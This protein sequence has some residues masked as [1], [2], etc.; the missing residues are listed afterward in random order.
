MKAWNQSALL[1]AI[2]CASAPAMAQST[3]FVEPTRGFVLER[4]MTAPAK[5]VSAD[6][7]AGL[8]EGQFGGGIRVGLPNSELILRGGK[9]NTA[10]PQAN[11]SNEALFKYS[12]PGLEDTDRTEFDWSLYGGFG[13]T[14]VDFGDYD[15]HRTN[16]RVGTA[17]TMTIDTLILNFA[18]EVVYGRYSVDGERNG[19]D[20]DSEDDDT[21][22]NFGVGAYFNLPETDYGRF[23]PGIEAGFST[24]DDQDAIVN[25]GVR[26]MVKDRV[27]LDVVMINIGDADTFSFPGV[28][29]LNV[30]F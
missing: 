21:Y 19:I 24:E 14:S 10:I 3:D 9:T 6:L 20:V 30:A 18:P 11:T 25:L 4:G 12:I 2:A 5:S 28:A 1:A 17:L 29:R 23:Q 26:W 7:E 13:H 15:E 8:E 22:V 16:M 27:T